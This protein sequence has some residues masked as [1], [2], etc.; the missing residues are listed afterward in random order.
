MTKIIEAIDMC[1]KNKANQFND[2]QKITKTIGSK[3][4]FIIINASNDP[5]NAR[6]I[7]GKVKEGTEV[8]LN[9]KAIKLEDDCTNEDILSIVNDCNAKKIPVILQ[10]PTFNHINSN[11][12]LE[13]IDYSVD[14]DCF[15]KQ[16]FLISYLS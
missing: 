3:P 8:G 5:G 1:S 12:I 7:E 16:Y 10:L 6:Y 4:E 11:M 15:N 9:V 2:V 14:A 13:N